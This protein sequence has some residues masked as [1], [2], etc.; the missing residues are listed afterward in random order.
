MPRP[1]R[2]FQGSELPGRGCFF[3]VS[4][5]KR[6]ENSHSVLSVKLIFISHESIGNQ[7]LLEKLQPLIHIAP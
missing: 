6:Y 4:K 1:S 5:Q 7:K 2:I 3:V